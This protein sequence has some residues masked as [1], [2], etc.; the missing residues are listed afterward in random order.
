MA[1]RIA[2][3]VRFL[4]DCHA[5]MWQHCAARS[6]RVVHAMQPLWVFHFDARKIAAQ[7]EE[8]GS[9]SVRA[10]RAGAFRISLRR[11]IRALILVRL[12]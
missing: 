9:L 6:V 10:A 5:R 4:L 7:C 3:F 8:R 1:I 12:R 2:R 11:V